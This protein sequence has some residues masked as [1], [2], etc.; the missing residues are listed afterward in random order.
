MVRCLRLNASH[1]E[2]YRWLADHDGGAPFA[3][4]EFWDFVAEYNPLVYIADVDDPEAFQRTGEE[5]AALIRRHHPIGP[6]DDILE[7]GCGMGR[8]LRPLSGACRSIHG[9]DIS[10][11][12]IRRARDYL[13]GL[14]NVTVQVQQG[15]R[16]AYADA[17]FSFVYAWL[18]FMHLPYRD[19]L[20]YVAEACRVL[21]PGGTF[22]FQAVGD[23]SPAAGVGSECEKIGNVTHKYSR[24]ELLLICREFTACDIVVDNQDRYA[25]RH[26]YLVNCRK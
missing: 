23:F 1:A 11:V 7:I 8:I 25:G 3:E 13:N 9:V 15:A 21:K 17:S 10:A 24:D 14:D 19:F 6:G 20:A 16:L 18:V 26:W 5:D 2:A 22:F 12:M 4:N